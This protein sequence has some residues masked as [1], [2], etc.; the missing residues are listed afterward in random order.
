MTRGRRAA[1]RVLLF[2][3]L[4]FL[5]TGCLKLTMDLDVAADDTVSG[6]AVF[7]FDDDILE[8][9][10]GTFDDALGG[11]SIVPSDV[12][13]V[14]VEPYAEDGFT[15]QEITFD[16]VPLAEFN[17]EGAGGDSL[18]I[19]REGDTFV[20]DGALDLAMEDVP[21][22]GVPFDPQQM[23]EDAEIRIA[24]TFPGEVSSTN[25]EVD[26]TTVTWTPTVGERTELNAVAS[27][28]GGGGSNLLWIVLAVVAVG[29][30]AAAVIVSN[31]RKPVTAVPPTAGE[32]GAVA[33]PP[34][35][36]TDVVPS[37]PEPTE[38]VPAQREPGE[39]VPPQPVAP[40]EPPPA[41]PAA[42]G[43]GDVPR[44]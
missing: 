6:T 34:P 16:A 17:Q 1:S 32:A 12:E 28:V 41:P 13:G 21:T 11:E 37:Q 4:T 2:G 14:S 7:A 33:A 40:P 18:S 22:E 5:L 43:E 30:I 25:G 27:A 31:R 44:S 20:V 8:L 29:A 19:V 39:V 15:G 3:A 24:L 10:G 42:P 26:G 36:P 23:F 9:A 38:P 35:T